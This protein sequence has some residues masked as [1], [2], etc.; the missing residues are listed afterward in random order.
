MKLITQL[1]SMAIL[2]I[3]LLAFADT[4]TQL[5]LINHYGKPLK[6]IAGRNRDV[7]PAFPETFM[8][9]NGEMKKTEVLDLH[10]QAFIRVE[11]PGSYN[12][13]FGVDAINNSTNVYGY[14]GDGIAYSW[15]NGTKNTVTF[16]T[17]QEYQ[18]KHS[19]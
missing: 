9:E 17:P 14:V 6:F 3:P 5:T 11:G 13:F 4:D 8:L 7:V 12:A 10:K 18:N 16:C 1:L 2:S 15:K 19:C